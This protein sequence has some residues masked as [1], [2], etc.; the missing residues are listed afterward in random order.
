MDTASTE[1][2]ASGLKTVRCSSPSLIVLSSLQNPPMLHPKAIPWGCK[3]RAE[4]RQK[5]S[6]PRSDGNNATRLESSAE[7]ADHTLLT[8]AES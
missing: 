6:R 4:G 7:G 3:A 1:H 2:E 8:Q 5:D